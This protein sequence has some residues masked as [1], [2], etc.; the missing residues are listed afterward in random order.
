MGRNAESRN[1]TKKNRIEKAIENRNN[2]NVQFEAI[3]R[4]IKNLL[5]NFDK[6]PKKIDEAIEMIKKKFPELETEIDH[7]WFRPMREVLLE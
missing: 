1:N 4:K 5:S 6:K 7:T 2:S 3:K